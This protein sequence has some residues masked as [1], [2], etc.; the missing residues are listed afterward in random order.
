[1]WSLSLLIIK[2][3][4]RGLSMKNELTVEG[5]SCGHCKNAVETAL[6][7]LDGVNEAEVDLDDESVVI[8]HE[9]VETE[10]L[11]EAIEDAGHYQVK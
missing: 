1:M 6:T 10:K 5:M 4:G 7:G 11:I 2:N 9:E 8:D 3:S